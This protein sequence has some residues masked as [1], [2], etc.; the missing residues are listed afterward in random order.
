M[1]WGYMTYYRAFSTVNG[2]RAIETDLFEG[3]RPPVAAPKSK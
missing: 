1:L 2:G 3:L